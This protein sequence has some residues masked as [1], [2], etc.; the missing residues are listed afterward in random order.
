M[1]RLRPFEI[2]PP[3]KKPPRDGEVAGWSK[4]FIRKLKFQVTPS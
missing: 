4:V 1:T 3:N 2:S